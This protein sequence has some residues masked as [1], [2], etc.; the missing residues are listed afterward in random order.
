[1]LHPA[2]TASVF[3]EGR[4]VGVIG[5]V[6]PRWA[7][8]EKLRVPVVVAEVDLKAL[9]RGQPRVVKFKPVSKFPA[10]ERDLAIVITKTMASIDVAQEIKKTSGAHM[11][12]VEV[13]DVFVGGD[14][15]PD[16][17]SVAYKMLFQDPQN[18]LDE[19]RLTALQA[20]IVANVAKKFGV[21]VR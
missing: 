9:S 21:K 13:F 18:T 20:Q 2:Q 15:S 5:A 19:A 17:Q 8:Q 16:S 10:V 14:L 1:L 6:H 7:S 4:N 11:Q 3:A 12:S